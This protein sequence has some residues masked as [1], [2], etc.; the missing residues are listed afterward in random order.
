[1]TNRLILHSTMSSGV[2]SIKNIHYS[3]SALHGFSSVSLT[4]GLYKPNLMYTKHSLIVSA[5]S[6]KTA[7]LSYQSH[8]KR[9][10]RTSSTGVRLLGN[11]IWPFLNK[12]IHELLPIIRDLR[13]PK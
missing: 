7:C 13:T 1:M 10:R 5:I 11:T 9:Q 6:G 4:A 3:C 2:L 8:G 12:F